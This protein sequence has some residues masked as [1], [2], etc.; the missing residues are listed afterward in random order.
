[1][2][3][4][5]LSANL[6]FLRYIL[7]KVIDSSGY[8]TPVVGVTVQFVGQNANAPVLTIGSKNSYI[9]VSVNCFSVLLAPI[10]KY[11][12]GRQTPIY[13]TN[14]S[15]SITDLD[16]QLYACSILTP[17]IYCRDFFPAT[18]FVQLQ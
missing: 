6:I 18:V 11:E 14:D 1:M 8:P 3:Y 4:R 15:L 16:H 9:Y 17:F 7:L 5:M 10:T 13:V 12:E 2:W